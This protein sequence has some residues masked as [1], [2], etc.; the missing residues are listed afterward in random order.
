MEKLTL[1]EKKEPNKDEI[2]KI[3][4]QNILKLFTQIKKGCNKKI[5]Y[6]SLC[7][8]NSFCKKSNYLFFIIFLYI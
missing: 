7:A 6:N 5:C 3:L 1:I 8:N 2:K 4:K